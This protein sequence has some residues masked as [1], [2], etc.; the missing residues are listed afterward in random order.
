MVVVS[1]GYGCGYCVPTNCIG[2]RGSIGSIAINGDNTLHRKSYLVVV[3]VYGNDHIP[4]PNGNDGVIA[5]GQITTIKDLD[6]PLDRKSTRLNSSHA[7]RSR[8][9]SSA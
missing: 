1:L 4:D 2:G 5:T 7:V 8:M 6:R 3:T 9:P